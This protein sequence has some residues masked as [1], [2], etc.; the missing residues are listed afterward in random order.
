MP[1]HD[2]R[3]VNGVLF[4]FGHTLFA[5]RSLSTTVADCAAALDA[6]MTARQSQ[7]IAL[8]IDDAAMAPAELV[9]PRDLDD[10]VWRQRWAV[11]YGIADEWVEGLGE[12]INTSMHDPAAWLPYQGA[13][14]TLHA[15]GAHGIAIGIISNTGWDVRAAFIFHRMTE[16]VTSFTLS[17]EAGAVKPDRQIF[18]VACDSLG[19]APTQVL[20]VGDDPRADSGAV[21]VGIRTYLV[22]AAPPG[23]DNGI[24]AVLE[25]AGVRR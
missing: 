15:L 19:L 12:A 18:D 5:H 8:R 21:R 22:P 6:P 9:H 24:G 17:Y 16:H 3:P 13:A 7:A 20:M 25:L 14:D 1:D 23:V 4:D 11:L 10:A 2:A